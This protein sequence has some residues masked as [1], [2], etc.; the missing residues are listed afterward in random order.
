MLGQYLGPDDLL[1]LGLCSCAW[2]ELGCSEYLWML[3]ASNLR[4]LH[5]SDTR[6]SGLF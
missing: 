1:L 2:Y 6:W 3:M 4:V 5:G